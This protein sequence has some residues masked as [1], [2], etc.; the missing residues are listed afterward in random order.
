MSDA[1]RCAMFYTIPHFLMRFRSPKMAERLYSWILY[2]SLLSSRF[3]DE[4]KGI[5]KLYQ[6][7]NKPC[8]LV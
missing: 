8:V 7:S 3:E 2:Y 6:F 4:G 1:S 5:M